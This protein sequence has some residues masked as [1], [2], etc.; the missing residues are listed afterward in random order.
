MF[1]KSGRPRSQLFLEILMAHLFLKG[2][3]NLD[4]FW[5]GVRTYILLKLFLHLIKKMRKWRDGLF[6]REKE[7]DERKKGK[8]GG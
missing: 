2:N 4:F 3:I 6:E 7:G 5:S 1:L 8:M